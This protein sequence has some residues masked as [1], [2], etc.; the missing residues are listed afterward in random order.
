MIAGY[1]AEMKAE[2]VAEKTL[3]G[4]KSGSFIVTCNFEGLMLSMATA[5]FSPQRSYIKAFCEVLGASFMQFVG[6]CFVW[7]WY[8]IVKKCT[9]EN[10]KIDREMMSV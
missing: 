2:D 7:N 3:N 4:I 10:N 6:L 9:T 1:S 8:G 5:G